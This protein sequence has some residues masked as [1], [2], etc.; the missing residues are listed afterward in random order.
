M[1]PEELANRLTLAGMEVEKISFFTPSLPR[2][3]VAKIVDAKPHVNGVSQVLQISDGRIQSQVVCSDPACK[4]GMHVAFAQ[5]G[6]CLKHPSGNEVIVKKTNWDGIPSFGTLCTERQIELSDHDTTIAELDHSSPLGTPLTD[7]LKETVLDISLTPNLGHCMSIMGIAR[8]L[9]AIVDET[10][11]LSSFSLDEENTERKA[12][13]ID[14]TIDD[15]SA[16]S[17]YSCRLIH[18]LQDSPRTAPFW[19]KKRLRT[20][21][22]RSLHPVVDVTNYVMLSTGQP[23]HA[24]DYQKIEGKKI[25][26]KSAEQDI[27][28]ETLDGKKRTVPKST[29]MIWDQKKPIAIAGIMG[30]ACSEVTENTRFVLLESAHF[31]SSLIR[32]AS[33]SLHIRS[34]SSLRFERGVD[35]E[36]TTR[37]LDEAAALIQQISGGQITRSKVKRSGAPSRKN[38][39]SLRAQKAN[40][41]LGTS[42]SV[43]EM[44]SCLRRLGIQTKT[45]NDQVLEVSVPSYRHDIKQEVDLIEEV[46]RIYGYHNLSRSKT[47]VVNSTLPHVPTYEIEQKIRTLF[48]QEGL[49]EFVTCSLIS[50]KLSEMALE[51]ELS[52][53]AAIHVL[54]PSSLD[55]SILR[56]SLLPGLLQAIKYNFDRKIKDIS[57]FEVGSVYFKDGTHFCERLA[58]AII[59]TGKHTPLHFE[60]RQRAIDFFDLKGIIENVRSHFGLASLLFSPSDL[61][62]FYPKKQ[63]TLHVGAIRVGVLGEI[64]PERLTSMDMCGPV[65]FAQLDLDD[66]LLF[67]PMPEKQIIL[68]PS[69]PCSDRDWTFSLKKEVPMEKVMHAVWTLESR[70][71][72][73]CALIDLYEGQPVELGYKNITLRLTYRDRKKTLKQSQVE[74]EHSRLVAHVS[75]CLHL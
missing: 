68:P 56:T 7:L 27:P 57:A 22:M 5:E 4:V 45:S 20:A 14:V 28:F 51:K 69:F 67:K 34:E 62:S 6:A 19:L 11:A 46:A 71:L 2:V 63:A 12:N 39:F 55:Q 32:F 72:E 48:L 10:I 37:A 66:L 18:N 40:A 61:K 26:V 42:L 3:I 53:R 29:L 17:L 44:E 43:S 13:A 8:E 30:G 36:Q 52:E 1:S 15:Q 21:G 31:E 47:R 65:F 25:W 60:T 35:L 75:S 58:A 50:P 73:Q 16:C 54:H 38:I 33:K 59:M 64:H 23:I 24:F 41:L 49:Q 9:C 74:K 70:L